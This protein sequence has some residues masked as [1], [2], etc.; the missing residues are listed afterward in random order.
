MLLLVVD[1]EPDILEPLTL[2]LEAMG[3]EVVSAAC[4]STALELF[5][6]AKPDAAF[7]DIGLPEVD[8]YELVRELRKGSAGRALPLIALSGYAADEDKQRGEQA[9]FD[10]YLTKPVDI[11]TIEEVLRWI[12]AAAESNGPGARSDRRHPLFPPRRWQYGSAP[13][14]QANPTGRRQPGR[15]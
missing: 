9:G 8:G 2:L 15:L 1:D 10:C 4:A 3:H 7:I 6:T 13:L 14:E 5:E 12:V 11:P